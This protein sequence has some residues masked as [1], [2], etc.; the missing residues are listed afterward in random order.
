M[1]ESSRI[2]RFYARRVLFERNVHV[3]IWLLLF[4]LPIEVSWSTKV[5]F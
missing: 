1:V 3:L 4:T 5:V 2:P